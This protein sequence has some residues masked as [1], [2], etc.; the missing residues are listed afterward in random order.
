MRV[1]LSTYVLS[2]TRGG[3]SVRFSPR[4]GGTKCRVHVSNLIL[5]ISLGP[6]VFDDVPSFGVDDVRFRDFTFRALVMQ[7]FLVSRTA[8][9][10]RAAP[11]HHSFSFYSTPSHRLLSSP[12]RDDVGAQHFA[13]SMAERRATFAL[14]C[15]Q[16]SVLKRFI[17]PL[18]NVT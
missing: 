2:S 12:K 9:K 10:M 4:G 1:S 7:I 3:G 13:G 8:R 11:N 6:H 17:C 14:C 15:T 18:C 5:R 16:R